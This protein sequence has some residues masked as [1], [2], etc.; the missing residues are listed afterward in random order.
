VIWEHLESYPLDEPRAPRLIF[1]RL[2]D[3]RRVA[4]LAA[5]QHCARF[6]L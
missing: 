4:W 1:Y 5:C 3:V 6:P 2:G